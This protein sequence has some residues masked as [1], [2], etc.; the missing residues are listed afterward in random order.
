V[1]G[2]KVFAL[3]PAK[4]GD[5]QLAGK[6]V[7][8]KSVYLNPSKGD[9]EGF[10]KE[11]HK[12]ASDL[13][14]KQQSLHRYKK[15]QA[16]S[17]SAL[18]KQHEKLE[19]STL[20][21]RLEHN[22]AARGEALK[23]AEPKKAAPKAAK[24][25]QRKKLGSFVMR[26][27]GG[28]RNIT[29]TEKPVSKD[30]YRKSHKSD[31]DLKNWEKHVVPIAVGRSKL[32]DKQEGAV[33][34]Y[35]DDA[36]PFVAPMLSGSDE[37]AD[38]P[39]ASVPTFLS[40]VKSMPKYTGSLHRGMML[41]EKNYRNL[42]EK[43]SNKDKL[44]FTPMQSWSASEHVAETFVANDPI[45]NNPNDPDIGV[46][47]HVDKSKKT[48]AIGQSRAHGQEYETVSLPGAQ[49]QL[50]GFKETA[51]IGKFQNDVPEGVLTVVTHVFLKEL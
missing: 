41:N 29:F 39:I 42:L 33:S 12:A 49:Y 19:A 7:S 24:S 46:L 4:L 25:T 3:D 51:V 17:G 43:A 40:A 14:F 28:E 45:S 16:I 48:H 6:T 35:Q 1:K 21:A 10:S 2:N 26:K 11:D 27:S 36:F 31:F 8:G 44:T 13:L 34:S 30:A 22:A 23:K 18:K 20:A 47:F 38:N 37:M 50:T 5:R 15:N 32:S 9:H